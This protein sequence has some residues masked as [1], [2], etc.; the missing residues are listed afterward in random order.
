MN[1]RIGLS[2][3]MES[4]VQVITFVAI[5]QTKWSTRMKK[6][7]HAKLHSQKNIRIKWWFIVVG[8]LLNKFKIEK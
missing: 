8:I 4:F 3:K 1:K 5:L 6:W 7:N 2:W